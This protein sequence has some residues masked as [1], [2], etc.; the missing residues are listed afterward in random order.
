MVATGCQFA[1][2]F[3]LFSVKSVQAQTI[4]K[5]KRMEEGH[6]C[7]REGAGPPH[8]NKFKIISHTPFV[9]SD[10]KKQNR[11]TSEV[12]VRG[13]GDLKATEADKT[14]SEEKRRY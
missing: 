13:A 7:K 6:I 12:R 10:M 8:L 3:V 14:T 1:F 2:L 5:V 9:L 11:L 4:R